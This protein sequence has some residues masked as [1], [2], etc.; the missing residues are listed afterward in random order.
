RG[1]IQGM[2]RPFH[3]A[4]KQP[5]AIGGLADEVPLG[6]RTRPPSAGNAPRSV[7]SESTRSGEARQTGATQVFP[8][9]RHQV[10]IVLAEQLLMGRSEDGSWRGDDSEPQTEQ[11]IVDPVQ[12][13]RRFALRFAERNLSSDEAHLEQARDGACE[14]CRRPPEPAG[15]LR[16]TMR[17]GS[18]RVE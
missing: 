12:A 1:V 9:R 18:Y 4:Q 17:A 13:L 2:G 3:L 7:P 6:S 14:R 5:A 10:R 8:R 16:D 11:W 15:N